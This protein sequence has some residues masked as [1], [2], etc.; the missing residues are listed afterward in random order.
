VRGKSSALMLVLAVAA[1]APSLGVAQYTPK[2][3][4]GDW[5]VVKTWEYYTVS[6]R[7][8]WH[9]TRY[10]VVRVEKVRNRECY[11]LE[12]GRGSWPNVLSS[13]AVNFVL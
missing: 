6:G 1:L 9:Y 3:H 4:V 8:E 11:V 13:R 12:I 2:W 10:D 5:W 7:P